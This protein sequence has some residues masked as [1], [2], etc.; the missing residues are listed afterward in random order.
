M[1]FISEGFA[2]RKFQSRTQLRSRD[3]DQAIIS[4]PESVIRQLALFTKHQVEIYGGEIV[5]LKIQSLCLHS[6]TKGAIQ[7][8]K[9]INDYFKNKQIEIG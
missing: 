1:K 8:S 2:D 9:T 5:P 4:D 6:D 7:L 3:L